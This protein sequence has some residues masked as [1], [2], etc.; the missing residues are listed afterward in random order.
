MVDEAGSSLSGAGDQPAAFSIMGHSMGD[1]SDKYRERISDERLK[2][3]VD[4]VHKWLFPPEADGDR[5]GDDL[6][7]EPVTVKFPTAG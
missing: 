5:E 1:I 3:V 2:A 7:D 4:Y 6:E